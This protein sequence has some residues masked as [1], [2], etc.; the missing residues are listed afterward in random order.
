MTAVGGKQPARVPRGLQP[1][2]VPDHLPGEDEYAVF[3]THLTGCADCG[4]GQTHCPT[5]T[6]LWRVYK[7]AKRAAKKPT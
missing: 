5:A 7:A 1:L 4:Y 2:T 6:E 3:M